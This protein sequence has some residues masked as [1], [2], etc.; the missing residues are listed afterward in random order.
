MIY[1]RG[2]GYK[3]RDLNTGG[4]IDAKVADTKTGYVDGWVARNAKGRDTGRLYWTAFKG[5]LA[6]DVIRRSDMMVVDK[7]RP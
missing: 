5:I 4:E 2:T 1:Y 6:F 3:F 7:A